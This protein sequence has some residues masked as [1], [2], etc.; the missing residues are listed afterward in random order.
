MGAHIET[1]PKNQKPGAT[2]FSAD[3][4]ESLEGLGFTLVIPA[5]NEE[6]ALASTLENALAA[7]RHVAENTPVKVM[8]VVL[9]NDGSTDRTQAIADQYPEVMKIRFEKNRGYG[10][11][12]LAGFDATNTPLVGFMD[13]DGSCEPRFLVPLINHL[14]TSK[15]D[16]VV[17][18]RMNRESEMPLVRRLGNFI[19]AR[20][21]CSV[22]GQKITDSASGMRVLQRS[23]LQHLHPL[24]AGLHF[25]P[26]MTCLALL[27]SRLRISEV[28]MPYKERVGD[29][30]LRV[31][32]D[33]F[34]FLFII[35]FTVA[36]F[37]PIKS[38]LFLGALFCACGLGILALIQRLGGSRP[39]LQA[40]A[41][42]FG[43]V[44]LQ[45]GFVG[46][47]CH[48]MLYM[49]LGPWRISGF[50]ESLLQRHFWTRK[51][52]WSGLAM[53]AVSLL[54]YASSLLLPLSCRTA[55]GL[56]SAFLIVAAGWTALAGVVLRVIW[57]AKQRRM[58]ER[59]VPAAAV[60]K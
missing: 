12:L 46:F 42:A 54:V 19:F 44:F 43:V 15:S 40:M 55:L 41:I 59:E 18:S 11:A 20:F 25:T 34:R 5:L 17:G 48:Q 2:S 3:N 37:N 39:A 36:L 56:L 29:S 16:I 23:S 60:N 10:A 58:V 26:A 49:L 6:E 8:K 30:K 22:C 24:P 31:I 14:L 57:A 13:A 50:A 1:D 52:V 33:G 38:L 45:A 32:K 47:L 28:P 9:V 53:L 35:L 51:M 27:D 4:A 7:R 21:I